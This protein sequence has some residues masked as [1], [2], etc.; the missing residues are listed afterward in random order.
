M[1]IKNNNMKFLVIYAYVLITWVLKY[2]IN[3][4]EL[5]W[6]LDFKHFSYYG[7]HFL[8]LTDIKDH[9]TDNSLLN[10]CDGFNVLE[11]LVYYCVR[12]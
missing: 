10:K 1:L 4:F 12:N 6:Y 8:S 7:T 2:T 9:E 3:T 11:R 5:L